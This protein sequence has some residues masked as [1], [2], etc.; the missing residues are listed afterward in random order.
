[1]DVDS[2]DFKQLEQHRAAVQDD[3]ERNPEFDYPGVRYGS[4]GGPALPRADDGSHLHRGRHQRRRR[5]SHCRFGRR[6]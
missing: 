6:R 4:A 1:M 2:F 3:S 5:R